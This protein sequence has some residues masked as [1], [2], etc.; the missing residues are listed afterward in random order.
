M[1]DTA[2]FIYSAKAPENLGRRASSIIE[3]AGNVLELSA[4]SL[5]EVAIKSALG[6][7]TFSEEVTRQAIERLNLR[8]LPFSA[9]HGFR[10]FSVPV[11]HRDPFDRQLIAQA[12]AESIPIISPDTEF[13]RY[14]GLQIIW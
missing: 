14:K 13:R 4:V 2:A 6:K 9:E 12:L 3:N 10:F 8:V 1:L 11:H 7:I 5:V